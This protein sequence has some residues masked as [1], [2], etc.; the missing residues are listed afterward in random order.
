MKEESVSKSR[1]GIRSPTMVDALI[2]IISLI[3]LLGGGV[4]LYGDGATS[5]P[6]QVALILCTM[7]VLEDTGLLTRLLR[8]VVNWAKSDSSLNVAI[9]FLYALVGFQIRRIE[10]A[11]ELAPLPEQVTLYGIGNRRAKTTTPDPAK[12]GRSVGI[13]KLPDSQYHMTIRTEIDDGSV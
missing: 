1:R 12:P 8:P 2:P 11:A 4:I 13:E 5:G 3:I 7:G 6:T 10:P 9:S